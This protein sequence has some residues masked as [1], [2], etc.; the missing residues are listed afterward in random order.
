M[1]VCLCARP[2]WTPAPPGSGCGARVCAWA[3]V[4][5]TPR[6]SWLGCLGVCVFVSAPRFYPAIPGCSVLCGRACAP[7][8]P[9]PSWWAACGA[10]LCGCC[11]AWGLP[12]PPPSPLVFF[13]GGRRGV[14]CHGFVV[15]V[16]GCSGFGSRGLRPSIPSRSGCVFV[17][18]FPSS[19]DPAWCVSASSG[20]PFSRLAAAPGL[21][22]LVLA[23]WSSRAPSGGPVFRAVW[24]GGLAASCGVDGRFCGCGPFS[25]PPPFFF[26][27]GSACSSLCLPWAGARTGRHSVWSSGLLLVLAFC[28][29]L[30]RPHVGSASLH[31]GLGSCSAGWAIAPGGFLWP[32]VRGAGVFRVPSPPRCWFQISHGGLCGQTATVVAGRAV[33]PCRCVAGRCGSFRGVWWLVLVRPSASVPC[34]GVL[35]CSGAPCCVLPCFAV[36]GRA[37]SCGVAVRPA[38][39]R[40]VAPCRAVV[41]CSVPRRVASC[42]GVLC[43]GVPCRGALHCGALRSGVPCCLVLCRGGSL[44]V[45]LARVV[46]RCAGRSVAGWWLGGAVR[47]GVARWVCA[48][49]VWVCRSGWCVG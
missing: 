17:C 43:L 26:P 14:S 33:A 38:G 16:A 40:C 20:C 28:Q 47:C 23:G 13:W 19:S 39:S 4:A 6:H 1:C 9:R 15:S 25:C 8:A 2:A 41:C 7:L 42:C 48:V 24:V 5:A 18:F 12:P 27:G 31:A 11:R 44:E 34:F 22:L 3:C 35:V 32:W 29:D 30:P 37:G 10:G 21:V 46:V 36:L 45:N 49:G